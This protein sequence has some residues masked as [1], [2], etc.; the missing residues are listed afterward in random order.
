[1]LFLK[2]LTDY[3]KCKISYFQVFYVGFLKQNLNIFIQYRL[4]VEKYKYS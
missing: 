3:L 4:Q 1:M 2:R